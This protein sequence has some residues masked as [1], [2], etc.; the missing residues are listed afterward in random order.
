MHWI[1]VTIP[2]IEITNH[3]D[4]QGIRRPD[5]EIDPRY[6]IDRARVR[7]HLLIYTIVLALPKE[8]QVEIAKNRWDIRVYCRCAFRRIIGLRCTHHSILLQHQ[9]YKRYPY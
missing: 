5:G 4:R 8:V 2:A 7:A 3:R 1:G 9:K 6:S